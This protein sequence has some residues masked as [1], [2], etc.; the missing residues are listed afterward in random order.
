MK[1]KAQ[2]FL[3]IETEVSDDISTL[4]T[5]RFMVDEDL[6]DLGYEI[7]S[8][9]VKAEKRYPDASGVLPLTDSEL[10]ELEEIVNEKEIKEVYISMGAVKYKYEYYGNGP[11][12]KYVGIIANYKAIIFLA[13]L[14]ELGGKE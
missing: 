7:H 14:F 8:I 11:C 2:L 9:A 1:I 3:D 5:L 12:N 6:K 13:T 10:R 4:D